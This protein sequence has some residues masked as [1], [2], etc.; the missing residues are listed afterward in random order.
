MLMYVLSNW[1]YQ[2]FWKITQANIVF[3]QFHGLWD[4][5]KKMLIGFSKIT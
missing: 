2:N 3:F 4:Q 1:P 5:N